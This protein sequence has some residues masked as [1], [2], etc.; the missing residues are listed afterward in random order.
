MSQPASSRAATELSEI[1]QEDRPTSPMEEE[2]TSTVDLEA[3]NGYG[4]SK[5]GFLPWGAS[6]I[7]ELFDELQ[8]S[9]ERGMDPLEKNRS[10]FELREELGRHHHFT[11]QAK[12]M[13]GLDQPSATFI[14]NFRLGAGADL[15]IEDAKYLQGPRR[16]FVSLLPIDKLDKLVWDLPHQPIGKALFS[17]FQDKTTEQGDVQFRHYPMKTFK[18][19]LS[20]V[21]NCFVGGIIGAPVAIQLLAVETKPGG[22][23]LYLCFLLSFAFLVQG[24][25]HGTNTQLFL[26]LG[27]AGVLAAI[28]K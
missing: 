12:E 2:A 9:E 27:Y 25:A 10:L 20:G 21:F 11:L 28:L 4:Q 8:R 14:D 26:T 24:I 5:K 17:R 7:L 6:N 18:V 1:H 19:V 22:A 15:D 3:G 16:D 23:V 13:H